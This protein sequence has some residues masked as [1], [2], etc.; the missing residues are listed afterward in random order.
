MINFVPAVY[1]RYSL[2]TAG[3]TSVTFLMANMR[4][5]LNKI[6]TVFYSGLCRIIFPRIRAVNFPC[7]LTW[8]K[9][10]KRPCYFSRTI[11]IISSYLNK[12]NKIFF[13]RKTI[14]S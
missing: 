7:I 12:E 4:L 9:D 3:F 8:K 6:V 10:L 14:R 11:M 5:C 2:L 1:F 13:R